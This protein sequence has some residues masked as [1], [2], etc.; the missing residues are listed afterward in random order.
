MKCKL[1]GRKTNWNESFGKEN[2][3]VCPK[4]HDRI[5][6]IISE[7]TNNHPYSKVAATSVIIELGYLKEEKHKS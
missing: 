3:I 4:C 2:F 5:A 1:C 7:I 6:T